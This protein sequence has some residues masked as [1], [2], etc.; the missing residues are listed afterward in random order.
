MR[1]LL[2]L[3]LTIYFALI[4]F[5]SYKLRY[6]SINYLVYVSTLYTLFLVFVFG[7]LKINKMT[8]PKPVLY[9]STINLGSCGG[10]LLNSI[11]FNS[12][13]YILV[14]SILF[15]ILLTQLFFVRKSISKEKAQN[16]V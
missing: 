13:T 4:L 1:R 11:L 8:T 15:T 3:S 5:C 7:Y 16:G 6:G 14:L 12:S 9:V 10:L 2:I